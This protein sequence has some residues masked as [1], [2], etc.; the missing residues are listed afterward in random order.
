MPKVTVDTKAL[1]TLY[2]WSKGECKTT[3][4]TCLDYMADHVATLWVLM[5]EK[6]DFGPLEKAHF[7]QPI[8]NTASKD[9]K[10]A[11][12]VSVLWSS[13]YR[14]LPTAVQKKL[15]RQTKEQRLDTEFF[16]SIELLSAPIREIKSAPPD[17]KIVID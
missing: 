3:A 6:G 9:K 15:D 12:V 13:V 8:P 11:M 17:S 4:P 1:V 14:T 10:I 16:R 2:P 7:T 5:K